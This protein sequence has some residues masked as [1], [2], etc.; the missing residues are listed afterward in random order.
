VRSAAEIEKMIA[1]RLRASLM[2]V[3][4]RSDL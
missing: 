4:Q 2:M 1:R 3:E